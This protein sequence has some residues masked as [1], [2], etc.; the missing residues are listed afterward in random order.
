MPLPPPLWILRPSSMEGPALWKACGMPAG[1]RPGPEAVIRLVRE[2]AARRISNPKR[3]GALEMAKTASNRLNSARFGLRTG[4]A[5]PARFRG[6][7]AVWP[8]KTSIGETRMQK[9]ALSTPV[10]NL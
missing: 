9:E 6:A 2:G 4:R 10:E 7:I 8:E 1:L 3:R 5:Y